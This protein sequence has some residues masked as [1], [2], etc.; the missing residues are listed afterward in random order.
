MSQQRRSIHQFK[1]FQE[2]T[3]NYNKEQK[4]VLWHSLEEFNERNVNN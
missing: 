4:Q 1:A 3:L 2:I